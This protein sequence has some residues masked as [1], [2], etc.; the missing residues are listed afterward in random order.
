ML[1]IDQRPTHS[2]QQPKTTRDRIIIL[3]HARMCLDDSCST[4]NC[5]KMKLVW[6]HILYCRTHSCSSP[7]CVSTRWALRHVLRCNKLLCHK[8]QLVPA[9][10]IELLRSD[11]ML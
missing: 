1:I 4:L 10:A 2:R 8:C 11:A 9:K 3:V 5:D 7:H 6:D